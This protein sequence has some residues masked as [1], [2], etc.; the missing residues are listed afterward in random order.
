[1]K[2]SG[3]KIIL[4][5]RDIKFSFMQACKIF[6]AQDQKKLKILTD[7]HMAMK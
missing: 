2:T 5:N 7:L 4:T 6:H 1:M 3:L